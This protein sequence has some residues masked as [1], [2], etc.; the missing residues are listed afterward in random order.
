MRRN[1]HDR[2]EGQAVNQR[3]P[4]RI[5]AFRCGISPTSLLL[6]LSLSAEEKKKK[7]SNHTPRGEYR[8]PQPLLRA[9]C[10]DC[11]RTDA[12]L[13]LSLLVTPGC[14]AAVLGAD[15]CACAPRRCTARSRRIGSSLWALRVGVL[16]L[17]LPLMM[18]MMLLLVMM[19]LVMLE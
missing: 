7:N 6:S 19:L 2:Y 4:N 9:L 18:M 14:A 17:L 8:S 13:S 15:S 5:F 1:V 3:R 16:L 11:Y 12:S 10:A